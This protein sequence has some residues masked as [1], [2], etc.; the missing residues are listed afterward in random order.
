M[1]DGLTEHEGEVVFLTRVVDEPTDDQLRLV[2]ADWLE[3]RG[4]ERAAFLRGV[5]A[6]GATMSPPDFPGFEGLNSEWTE[7]VGGRLLYELAEAECPELR[8]PALRLARPAL[9]I[10]RTETEDDAIPVGASK[11]GGDPDLPAGLAWPT[12]KD[13][14]AHYNEPTTDFGDLAGFL[15]QV[16]LDSIAHTFAG[17]DLPPT[18]LLSFFSFTVADNPDYLGVGA[19]HFPDK[20]NLA[21]TEPPGELVDG[22]EPLEPHHLDFEEF[23]DVPAL[24]GPW[25]DEMQVDP[26]REYYEDLES[27]EERNADNLLGYARGQQECDPTPD[28]SSRHLLMIENAAMCMLYLQIPADKLAARDFS[29]ITLDWV[30]FD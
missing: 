11:M 24:D 9:R 20:S 26:D 19:F 10:V 23:L 8:A 25:S 3:E 7:L 29:A 18:G 6:A 16:D 27:L 28:R 15:L 14:P 1:A 13:C 17:R 4:D 21:R 22:N 2:Y 5:V 30:D 12:G